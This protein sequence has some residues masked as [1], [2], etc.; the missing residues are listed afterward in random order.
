M[1]HTLLRVATVASVL[2][3]V[4]FGVGNFAL[5]SPWREVGMA[6]G[7]TF[8]CGGMVTVMWAAEEA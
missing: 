6:L 7:A 2:G 1:K 5:S 8:A 3:V 4:I